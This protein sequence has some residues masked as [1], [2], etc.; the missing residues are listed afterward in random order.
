MLQ[1]E[2]LYALTL[3]RIYLVME[4]KTLTMKIIIIK[5]GDENV[6]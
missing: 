5:H 6:V 2:L 1:W 3:W 4:F